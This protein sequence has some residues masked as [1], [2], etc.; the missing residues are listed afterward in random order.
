MSANLDHLFVGW[1]QTILMK[2][3]DLAG[4]FFNQAERA[5]VE[6]VAA[7]LQAHVGGRLSLFIPHLHTGTILTPASSDADQQCVFD[8]DIAAMEQADIFVMIFDG[9]DTGTSFEMGWGYARRKSM[10]GLWTDVRKRPNLMLAQSAEIVSTLPDL[11]LAVER[12]L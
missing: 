6:K 11:L 1:A 12:L 9:E 3:L 7:E 5:F 4:P 2:Y 10:V 8:S